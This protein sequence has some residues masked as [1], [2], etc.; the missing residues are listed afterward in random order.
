[1]MDDGTPLI[2]DARDI[3]K[4]YGEGDATV[5]V[6]HGVHLSIAAGEMVVLRGP[7]GS[8]KSTLLN[9]LGCLDRPT[10]GRYMLGGADVSRLDRKEQAWVR[11]N[12]LGFIFQSFHLLARSTALENAMLPLH[13]A[14]LD[15]KKQRTRALELL[16]RVGLAHRAAHFPNQLSGGERQR[17]AIARALALHPRLLLADEPTGALDSHT[18]AEILELIAEVRRQDDLTVVMVTHDPTVAA[19]TDRQIH[20]LDGRVVSKANGDGSTV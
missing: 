8:G 6:L 20:L 14:G 3:E 7:S 10:A 18:G 12:Y 15:R 4:R 2:V 5:E 13:Y 9:I 1:M 17:V 19:T 11:L 16:S